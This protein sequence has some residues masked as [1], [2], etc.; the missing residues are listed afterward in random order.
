MEEKRIIEPMQNVAKFMKHWTIIDPTAKLTIISGEFKTDK[1]TSHVYSKDN[2]P[3]TPNEIKS[4]LHAFYTK[5]YGNDVLLNTTIEITSKQI[6]W[7]THRAIADIDYYLKP[8]KSKPQLIGIDML[9]QVAVGFLTETS[10]DL[11]HNRDDILWDI[12]RLCEIGDHIPLMCYDKRYFLTAGVPGAFYNLNPTGLV[13]FTDKSTVDDAKELIYGNLQKKTW[14]RRFIQKKTIIIPPTPTT[15]IPPQIYERLMKE[16][17]NITTTLKQ[18]TIDGL[19]WDQ[20]N[21]A[22]TLSKG[23]LF[24]RETK[25][26]G[27]IPLVFLRTASHSNKD[28]ELTRTHHSISRTTKGKVIMN[29]MPE[30]EEHIQKN[31]KMT[32]KLIANSCSEQEYAKIFQDDNPLQAIPTNIRRN[33]IPKKT[34]SETTRTQAEFIRNLATNTEDYPLPQTTQHTH[35]KTRNKGTLAYSFSDALR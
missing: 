9:Q 7:D 32:K 33:L 8:Q 6:F 2:P 30:D 28:G 17:I 20:A 29:Y 24:H 23:C 26:T 35:P 10:S 15:S 31:I 22:I 16:H 25:L 18:C 3:N 4:I 12:K 27:V 19:N 13:L 21:T 1:H 5:G 34:I 14:D 11:L